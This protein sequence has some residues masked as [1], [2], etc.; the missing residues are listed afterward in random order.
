MPEKVSKIDLLDP[1][2]CLD[3]FSTEFVDIYARGIHL[4]LLFRTGLLQGF[5][6]CGVRVLGLRNHIVGAAVKAFA[7]HG[8]AGGVEEGLHGQ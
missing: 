8:I 5:R 4:T 1:I 6:L 7:K 3:F 2:I